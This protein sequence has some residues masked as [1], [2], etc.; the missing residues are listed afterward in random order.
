MIPNGRQSSP[1]VILGIDAGDPGFIRRWAET[2]HLPTI[3]SIM[4]RGCWGTTGGPELISEHG[5]WVSLF[6]GISR[7]R[8]GYYYFR[9][10]KP[11][12]YDLNSVTGLDVDAPPF[13]SYLVGRG[14]RVAIIDVPDS[15]PIAGLAGLQL[16]NWASHNNWDPDHFAPISEPP[17]I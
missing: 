16:A 6:S 2:G 9:Q 17:E 4:Q 1:L 10:L 8:H 15:R 11:G 7:G 3:A 14:H 5:V 12:T 13:W